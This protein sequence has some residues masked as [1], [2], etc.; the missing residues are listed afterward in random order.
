MFVECLLCIMPIAL[1]AVNKMGNDM[2]EV[3]LTTVKLTF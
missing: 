2:E 3:G 1:G